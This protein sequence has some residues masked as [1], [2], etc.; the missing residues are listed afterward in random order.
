VEY[1]PKPFTPDEIRGATER[2]F[3][4]AA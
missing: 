2:A 1:L 3:K 4:L